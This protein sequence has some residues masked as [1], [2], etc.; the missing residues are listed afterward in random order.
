MR[1]CRACRGWQGR[2]SAECVSLSGFRDIVNPKGMQ[3]RW[4]TLRSSQFYVQ[5]VG[6]DGGLPRYGELGSACQNHEGT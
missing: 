5:A 3:G 4:G 1:A 6:G 2:W